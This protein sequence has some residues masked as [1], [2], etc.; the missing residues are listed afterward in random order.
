ML[1]IIMVC[2]T[3]GL[4]N[5]TQFLKLVKDSESLHLVMK[6]R[7]VRR[8]VSKGVEDVCPVVGRPLGIDVIDE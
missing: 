4:A 6:S 7:G 2:L 1:F 5:R 8:G 3:V